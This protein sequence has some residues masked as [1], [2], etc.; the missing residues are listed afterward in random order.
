[1]ATQSFI[2][3]QETAIVQARKAARLAIEAVNIEQANNGGFVLPENR[4]CWNTLMVNA[5]DAR[6]RLDELIALIDRLI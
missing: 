6:K 3:E 4:D 2:I 1:M 5:M